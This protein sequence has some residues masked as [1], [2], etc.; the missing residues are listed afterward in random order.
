VKGNG[1]PVSH[2]EQAD[3]VVLFS[4]TA[5][6]LQRKLNQFFGACRITIIPHHPGQTQNSDKQTFLAEYPTVFP[7]F[8][9]NL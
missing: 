6:G 4:T 3:D 9:F 1:R 8:L 7:D 2:L 5:A